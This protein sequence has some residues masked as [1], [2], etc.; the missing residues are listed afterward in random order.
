VLAVVGPG[1]LRED[2]VGEGRSGVVVVEGEVATGFLE[3][4]STHVATGGLVAQEMSEAIG[5]LGQIA[6]A[7][8]VSGD[9]L[10]NDVRRSAV[11]AADDDE[12]FL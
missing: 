12:C 9:V 3:C 7:H 4:L 11:S 10:F 1:E 5:Q 6:V 2:D 8:E